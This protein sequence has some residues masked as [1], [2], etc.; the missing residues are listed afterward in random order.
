MSKTM[1]ARIVNG[2]LEPADRLDLPEG[3]EVVITIEE[4]AGFKDR[5]ERSRRA[6]GG[7]KGIIDC[8][9]LIRNIY[10]DRL[11]ST[12]PEPKL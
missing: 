9:G 4:L 7:W 1:R 3:A 5:E 8:E 11:I 12:R 10:A 6:A 2:R